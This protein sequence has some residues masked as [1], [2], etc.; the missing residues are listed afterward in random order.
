MEYY[1]IKDLG[2]LDDAKIN[3]FLDACGDTMFNYGIDRT[4]KLHAAKSTSDTYFYH[5]TFPA[6]HSLSLF[7]TDHSIRKHPLSEMWYVLVRVGE[8]PFQKEPSSLSEVSGNFEQVLVLVL[9]CMS[10]D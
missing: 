8:V 6:L 2:E 7:G 4:V 10:K 9:T 3:R 1:K 5:L